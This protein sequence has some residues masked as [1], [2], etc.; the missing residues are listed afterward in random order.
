V[1]LRLFFDEEQ[2][3]FAI[4]PCAHI[5]VSIVIDQLLIWHEHQTEIASHHDRGSSSF[6]DHLDGLS[7]LA[8]GSKKP[9]ASRAA[10]MQVWQQLQECDICVISTV[11]LLKCQ[12]RPIEEW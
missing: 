1:Y 12:R 2:E 5:S 10:F 8:D 7:E 3:L 11:R 9:L 6:D 4:I